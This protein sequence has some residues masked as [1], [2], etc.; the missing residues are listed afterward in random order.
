[1]TQDR[2][3]KG[4]TVLL[5]IHLTNNFQGAQPK[6]EIFE[7]N[8]YSICFYINCSLDKNLSKLFHY[9]LPDMA[10]FFVNQ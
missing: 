3:T 8:P 4:N 5:S 6:V 1:M 2:T 9:P 7:Q 10:E